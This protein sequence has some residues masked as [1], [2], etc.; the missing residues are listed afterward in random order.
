M[1]K[2]PKIKPKRAL[3]PSV[4]G[5]LL[6][7]EFKLVMFNPFNAQDIISSGAVPGF[8]YLCFLSFRSFFIHVT[9]V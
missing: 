2:E 9:A 1:F 4:L 7:S 6:S 3:K 8:Y 5:K